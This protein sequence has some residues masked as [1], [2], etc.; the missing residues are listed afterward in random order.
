MEEQLRKKRIHVIAVI[1]VLIVVAAGALLRVSVEPSDYRPGL[2]RRI[3][4]AERLIENAS[5]GNKKGEYAPYTV[6]MF[7]EQI[8]SAR[9]VA[10]DADSDYDTLKNAKKQLDAEINS[11]RNGKNT[12]VLSQDE[13]EKLAKEDG[14][15]TETITLNEARSLTWSIS[16]ENIQEAG[17]WNLAVCEDGPYRDMMAAYMEKL[18]MQG[19]LLSFYHDGAFP[20]EASVTTYFYSDG[21]EAYVYRL[22]PEAGALCYVTKGTAG[23]ETVTF[24]LSRGGTYMILV[25]ELSEYGDEE[26]RSSILQEILKGQKSAGSQDSD[27]SNADGTDTKGADADGTGTKNSAANE[28]GTKNAA[29]NQ[30][31]TAGSDQQNTDANRTKTEESGSGS[32]QSGTSSGN[33]DQSSQSGAATDQQKDSAQEQNTEEQITVSITIECKTLTGEGQKNLEDENLARYIPSDGIILK[34][35]AYTCGKDAT[36]YDVLCHVCRNHS[37]QLDS[38]YTPMYGNAYIKGINYLYE[39]AGGRY[40]G[41]IYRVNGSFPNC[42]CSSYQLKDGDEIIWSY[43]CTNGDVEGTGM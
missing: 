9:A 14:T 26:T 22:D 7:R 17:D 13:V 35:T 36:V 6:M 27:G 4:K 21:E 39:F 18:G 32:G 11:F 34:R 3:T 43:T 12:T 42:G 29:A 1:L 8:D 15:A 41:W 31:G 2:T 37:I 19:I 28:T 5:V 30:T 25:K 10:E 24:S 16:G 38:E 33:T 40:S 20:G 23:E